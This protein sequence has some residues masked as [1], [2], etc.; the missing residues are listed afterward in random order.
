MAAITQQPQ[1]QEES[2]VKSQKRIWITFL[3]VFT[4]ASTLAALPSGPYRQWGLVILLPCILSY[5]V[6]RAITEISNEQG[7]I[8]T[9]PYVLATASILSPLMVF[10]TGEI[11]LVS[12][13]VACSLFGLVMLY[14]LVAVTVDFVQTPSR[15]TRK[16]LE[17]T[18]QKAATMPPEEPAKPRCTI[19]KEESQYEVCLSCEKKFQGER[20]RVRAQILRAKQA[21]VPATLTLAEW[22]DQLQ[23]F[24]NRCAYCHK[25]FQLIE[26]YIPLSQGGGTTKENCIPA[27]FKCNAKKSGKHPEK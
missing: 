23:T 13:I 14:G 5:G 26:H 3:V 17:K 25:P 10:S 19:C 22:L 27:C 24:H 9:F 12:L 21:N 18:Q 8:K 15:S 2:K 1:T 4:L 11:Q 16:E 20:H 7:A 6:F